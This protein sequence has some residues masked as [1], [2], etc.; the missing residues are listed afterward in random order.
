MLKG[1]VENK[2]HREFP[3]PVERQKL[4]SVAGL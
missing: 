1:K 3:T 2:M 4:M